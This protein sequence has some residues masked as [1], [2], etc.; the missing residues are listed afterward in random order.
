VDVQTIG[1]P[2]GRL[3]TG[4]VDLV[5]EVLERADMYPRL[6]GVPSR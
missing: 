1:P 5:E 6:A 3:Q 4:I 2:H